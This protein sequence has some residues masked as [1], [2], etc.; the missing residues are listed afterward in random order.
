MFSL[1]VDGVY[2]T[3]TT[4]WLLASVALVFLV[5]QED[6]TKINWLTSE[7]SKHLIANMQAIVRE[8]TMCNVAQIATSYRGKIK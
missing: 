2:H 8:F 4:N 6:V 7:P 5:L 1:H 3:T